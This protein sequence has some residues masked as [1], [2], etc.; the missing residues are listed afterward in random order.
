MPRGSTL[1]SQLLSITDIERGL[2]SSSALI[3][4]SPVLSR[5]TCS[6]VDIRHAGVG[7]A[8]RVGLDGLPIVVRP[9]RALAP[10]GKIGHLQPEAEGRESLHEDLALVGG[11]GGDVD[12]PLGEDEGEGLV[13]VGRLALLPQDRRAGVHGIER[14]GTP[15]VP[16]LR[17]GAEVELRRALGAGRLP[18]GGLPAQRP[19]VRVDVQDA[20]PRLAPPRPA[21]LDDRDA[22]PEPG[23]EAPDDEVRRVGTAR[24]RHRFRTLNTGS[25]VVKGYIL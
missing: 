21:V 5:G 7:V 13:R 6:G 25:A 19:A 17:A 22:R 15:R 1:A 16:D 8:H 14:V 10:A 24:R 4:T 9:V 20:Q 12:R 18:E 11:D 23:H 3:P 2:S